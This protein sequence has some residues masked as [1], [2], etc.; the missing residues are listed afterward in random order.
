M[1]DAQKRMDGK[2]DDLEMGMKDS[3]TSRKKF[4][5]VRGYLLEDTKECID[6]EIPLVGLVH[7][8]T[9]IK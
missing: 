4:D 1:R 2:K 6:V 5:G 9:V 3:R 7:D 8:G